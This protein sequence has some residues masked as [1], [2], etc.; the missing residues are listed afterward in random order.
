[1]AKISILGKMLSIPPAGERREV[2]FSINK[3]FPGFLLRRDWD[4][5][6]YRL[7]VSMFVMSSVVTLIFLGDILAKTNIIFDSSKIFDNSTIFLTKSSN[8]LGPVGF[9]LALFFYFRIRLMVDLKNT[10]IPYMVGPRH[11]EN[12]GKRKWAVNSFL[13]VVAALGMIF[14]SDLAPRLIVEHY[15]LRE[16][17]PFIAVTYLLQ[18]I[19]L[20]YGPLVL[21]HF[22]L[23]LEKVLRFFSFVRNDYVSM[24]NINLENW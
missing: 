5:L 2:I 4:Y 16:S 15:Q 20:T 11:L 9:I 6:C 10:K 21:V 24:N 3:V 19:C 14:F 22:S 18:F 8:I 1:M 13:M 17:F 12:A 23:M 7:F